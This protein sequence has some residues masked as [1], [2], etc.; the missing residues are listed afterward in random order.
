MS[1][2]K[3]FDASTSTCSYVFEHFQN[4]TAMESFEYMYG[5]IKDCPK[6]YLQ[7]FVFLLTELPDVPAKI[8]NSL[9]FIHISGH[10]LQFG[11]RQIWL[12]QTISH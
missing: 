3:R 9:R 5:L 8:I 1:L 7:A 10:R 4:A 12:D 6:E 2:V 11:Y